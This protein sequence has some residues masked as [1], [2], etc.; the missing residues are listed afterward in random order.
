MFCIPAGLLTGLLVTGADAYMREIGD[1]D[2]AQTQT[3]I[4]VVLSLSGLWVLVALSRPL[5]RA[6]ALIVVAMYVMFIG[7]FAIPLTRDFFG[8]VVLPTN[9][10]AVAA[11]FG[12]LAMLS[13]EGVDR[14][15]ARIL[16]RSQS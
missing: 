1:F 16:R 6:R 2:P 8:F 12:G 14:V 3:V 13:I 11:V 7:M 15:V 5:N 4:A 10:L 9:L